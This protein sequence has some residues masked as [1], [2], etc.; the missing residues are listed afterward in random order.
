MG[1]AFQPD[2]VGEQLSQSLRCGKH[3]ACVVTE[4]CLGGICDSIADQNSVA[5]KHTVTDKHAVADQNT[6]S[7]VSRRWAAA[8]CV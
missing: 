5:Y 6:L 3:T 2:P 8:H 1:Q 4:E 7:V